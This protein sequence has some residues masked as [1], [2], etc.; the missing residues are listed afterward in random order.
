[1]AYFKGRIDEIHASISSYSYYYEPSKWHTIY[2]RSRMHLQTEQKINN[3]M[4]HGE[5]NASQVLIGPI[6][7][8]SICFLCLILFSEARKY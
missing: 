2:S 7:C 3:D 8:V 5:N 1:M 4:M 6:D